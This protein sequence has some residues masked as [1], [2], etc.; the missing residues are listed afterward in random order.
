MRLIFF[1]FL[2]FSLVQS[3]AQD[4]ME[5]IIS[6]LQEVDTLPSNLLMSKT[7]V[8]VNI[9]PS[10]GE[11]WEN[12][13][14][15]IH[16]NLKKPGIDPVAYY[17]INDIYSGIDVTRSF[18]LDFRKREIENIILV[19]YY[20]GESLLAVLKADYSHYIQLE[21][22]LAWI[23]KGSL[24][25]VLNTL[26]VQAA[27]SGIEKTN[28]LINDIP[29]KGLL[30]DPVGGNRAAFF[31]IDLNDSKLAIPVFQDMD[32]SEFR[33]IMDAYY[34]HDYSFVNR[35]TPEPE[36]VGMG[37][38]YILRF[39][40]GS[41]LLIKKYLKYPI[42]KNVTAYPTVRRREGKD[43]IVPI[44]KD[45]HIYK[46]YIKHLSGGRMFIGNEWDTDITWKDALINHIN[47]YKDEL[48]IN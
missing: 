32:T 11:E 47:S 36:L 29:E 20:P 39:V 3:T 6:S 44:P 16:S 13:T 37:Y 2:L 19:G 5:N 45:Q 10:E 8:L 38:K 28:L 22:Q 33:T 27:N 21:S 26:Y 17:Y 41:G 9:P 35:D 34:P 7:V 14:N 1:T 30:T 43:E 24:K 23:R 15:T 42:E 40:E 12:I 4:R 25:E 46:F 18:T 31:S 48:G